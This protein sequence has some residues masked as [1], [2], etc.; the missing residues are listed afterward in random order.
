VGRCSTRVRTTCVVVLAAVLSSCSTL[1]SATVRVA[2]AERELS[3]LMGD[4]VDV[5]GVNETA[6]SPFFAPRSCTRAA[7]QEGAFTAASVSGVVADGVFR[8]D[9]VAG[10]LLAAGFELQ[11]SDFS[12]EVFGRRDG[13]WLTATFEPRRGIVVVDANTGCRAT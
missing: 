13:M 8:G 1:G 11:R 5:L 6:A 7:G 2:E 10:L 12:L 4:V 3:Q 9:A